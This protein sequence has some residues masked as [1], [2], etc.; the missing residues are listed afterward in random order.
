M[1]ELG[2]RRP[3]ER[4]RDGN[5]PPKAARATLLSRPL[6]HA[7]DLLLERES[8]AYTALW[9]SASLNQRRFLKGLA[10]EPEGVRVFA[11]D[12]LQRYNLRSPSNAQRVVGSLMEKDVIDRNDSSFVISDRFFKI[13]INQI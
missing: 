12:F 7:I 10:T 3:T 11:S 13:W 1:V 2:T 6:Y 8:Y 5:S 4:V 9:E